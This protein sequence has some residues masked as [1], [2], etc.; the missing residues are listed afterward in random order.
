MVRGARA[1]ATAGRASA[2]GCS[3]SRTTAPSTCCARAEAARSMRI[4]AKTAS[5]ATR[6]RGLAAL[7]APASATLQGDELAF[8]RC[9]P[10]R[11]CS[12]SPGRTAARAAQRLL[13]RHDD[14]LAL[15]DV[16]HAFGGRPETAKTR[17]AT[18]CGKC[19][20]A[21][22]LYPRRS[23]RDE[24]ER[25]TTTICRATAW[26]TGAA[27]SSTPGRAAAQ[28]ERDHPGAWA[29]PPGGAAASE[30]AAAMLQ[31][32]CA[33]LPS[34]RWLMA[35]YCATSTRC[36]LG[37]PWP[38]VAPARK[39]EP[40]SAMA[41][42]DVPPL[43][44]SSA[45]WHCDH[46]T[47]A[48]GTGGGCPRAI[49]RRPSGAVET[50]RGHSHQRPPQ[51]RPPASGAI[52]DNLSNLRFEIAARP[53]PG[54]GSATRRGARDGLTRCELDRPGRPH[55][56]TR[57]ARRRDARRSRHTLRFTHVRQHVV[58]AVLR[59]ERRTHAHARRQD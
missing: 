36:G 50:P 59:L 47:S 3:R 45:A 51:R 29:A 49:S 7:A 25:I 20:P 26:S 21:W 11:S 13:L 54:A 56:A 48:N 14:G 42:V 15:A 37:A 5:L 41:K 58:R 40:L 43:F 31:R 12:A 8:W 19:A 30:R 46:R 10:A 44:A 9:V 35:G 39:P 18:R 34:A 16:A 52:R 33:T 32:T 4:E 53:G 55:H 2:P 27:P 23:G 24:R 28:T 57:L 22:A 17:P 1:L 6:D 38:P